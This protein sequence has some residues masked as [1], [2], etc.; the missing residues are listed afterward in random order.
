[1]RGWGGRKAGESLFGF[2][3]DARCGRGR[4]VLAPRASPWRDEWGRGGAARLA[5]EPREKGR[6]PALGIEAG[7]RTCGR[8][9]KRELQTPAKERRERGVQRAPAPALRPGREP[10]EAGGRE[11][12][13]RRPP[14]RPLPPR[15]RPGGA[16][17]RD[18]GAGG[19][20]SPRGPA[21]ARRPG[22]HG[23]S[24]EQGVQRGWGG[25]RAEAGAQAGSRRAPLA[26][27]CTTF[28]QT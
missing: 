4:G 28:L 9:R 12:S 16:D 19:R 6:P 26:I 11:P 5:P 20:G 7:G 8:S 17:R 24:E 1:M 25:D 18:S 3:R 27:A 21:L 13:P 10:R 15:L 22:G 14:P 2:R 23:V